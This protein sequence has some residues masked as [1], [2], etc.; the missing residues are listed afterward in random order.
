MDYGNVWSKDHISNLLFGICMIKKVTDNVYVKPTADDRGFYIH[1][2]LVRLVDI[3]MKK[4]SNG[5]QWSAGKCGKKTVTESM[6]WFIINDVS[7]TPAS[8]DAGGHLGNVAW[9]FNEM[10]KYITGNDY[11]KNY[12]H[13]WKNTFP[14]IKGVEEITYWKGLHLEWNAYYLSHIR[15]YQNGLHMAAP[16]QSHYLKV[17]NNMSTILPISAVSGMATH[18][19]IGNL[20][21]LRDDASKMNAYGVWEMAYS[22]FRDEASI[23]SKGMIEDMLNLAPLCTNPANG[24]YNDELVVWT[25]DDITMHGLR[26]HT[27]E[28]WGYYSG[29]DYMLMYNLYRLLFSG[30]AGD[31]GGYSERSCECKKSNVMEIKAQGSEPMIWPSHSLEILNPLTATYRVKVMHEQYKTFVH[32][33]EYLKLFDYIVSDLQVLQGGYLQVES[34]LKLANNS[35]LYV[36]NYGRMALADNKKSK[37]TVYVEAGSTIRVA[38]DGRLEIGDEARLIFKAGS[39][40]IIEPGGMLLIHGNGHVIIEHD[41]K[42]LCGDGIL[43]L[44]SAESQLEIKGAIHIPA[45][46]SFEPIGQGVLVFNNNLPQTYNS[47]GQQNMIA[48]GPGAKI[49]F[50]DLRLHVKD[51][52]YVY[53]FGLELV[54]IKNSTVSLGK[55]AHINISDPMHCDNSSF[56]ALDPGSPE[57]NGLHVYGQEGSDSL[58]SRVKITNCLFKDGNYGIQAFQN[59]GTG[60]PIVVLNSQFEN[61]K[62][63][64]LVYDKG[65]YAFGNTFLECEK[66][67]VTELSSAYVIFESNSFGRKSLMGMDGLKVEGNG[68][69]SIMA[70]NVFYSL[71]QG[72]NAQG[73]THGFVCN[74]FVNTRVGVE[75]SGNALINWSND[76]KNGVDSNLANLGSGFNYVHSNTIEGG[77]QFLLYDQA[78]L[79]LKNGYNHFDMTSTNPIYFAQGKVYRS[80]NLPNGYLEIDVD[81]SNNSWVN[82][83]PNRNGEFENGP[84]NIGN[85][86]SIGFVMESVNS[87]DMYPTIYPNIQVLPLNS[88]SLTCPI[89]SWNGV[90]DY[91][92]FQAGQF[93]NQLY[94]K[95]PQGGGVLNLLG[96]SAVNIPS[97]VQFNQILSTAISAFYQTVG[98]QHNYESEGLAALSNVATELSKDWSHYDDEWMD[99][100]MNDYTQLTISF[101]RGTSLAEPAKQQLV[102]TFAKMM[103]SRA[104]YLEE[105]GEQNDAFYRDAMFQNILV[106]VQVYR[107]FKDYISAKR[108]V[109]EAHPYSKPSNVWLLE[110]YACAIEQES[111]LHEKRIDLPM[112]SEKITGCLEKVD[113]IELTQGNTLNPTTEGVQLGP[114]SFRIAPNPN[115]GVFKLDIETRRSLAQ[116]NLRVFDQMGR[117][118]YSELINEPL[119][120][121]FSLP[122]DLSDKHAGI[123]YVQ[124]FNAS[125]SESQAFVLTK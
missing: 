2:E 10:A 100:L 74:S 113:S 25:K 75:A 116:L 29:V 86:L 105:S 55:L 5:H 94:R 91:A 95:G 101:L 106:Q 59:Y 119:T 123:Y 61:L 36:A 42:L 118:V 39:Q 81:Y 9:P 31:D 6:N 19:H 13:T 88:L 115:S 76:L 92:N 53:P 12:T 99:N 120:G 96:K 8:K 14:C 68:F 27:H 57:H 117:L 17:I 72:Y 84:N 125:W 107:V 77:S 7:S 78:K 16:D 73:G 60:K 32:N 71:S 38:S 33:G 65:L 124:L 112:F 28:H 43:N 79:N 122:L 30:N 62:C 93:P 34:D 87:T 50:N 70:G 45:N 66:A 58:D 24:Y 3:W 64:L 47:G 67:A 52:T 37:K 103:K 82:F 89:P 41:A 51:Y 83:L 108:L 102:Q 26:P 85:L 80:S 90:Y 56:L 11:K 98:E 111:K 21:R 18:Q 23:W 46:Q 20:T 35:E 4:F 40:L 69:R 48:D 110:L 63:G 104:S 109:D 15:D 22:V 54:E 97:E 49:V 1:D 44:L 114:F 121:D